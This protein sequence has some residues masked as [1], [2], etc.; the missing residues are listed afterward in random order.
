MD[1]S[2]DFA[3]KVHIAQESWSQ[4]ADAKAAVLFSIVGAFLA[5]VVAILTSSSLAPE[6]RGWRL[7]LLAIGLIGALCAGSLSGLVLAPRL[8]SA[9]ELA[10]EKHVI[11]FGHLR[12]WE[13]NALKGKLVSMSQDEQLTQLSA[14]LVRISQGNWLKFRLLLGALFAVSIAASLVVI[15]LVWPH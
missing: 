1:Q 2:L 9:K 6:V 13:P 10:A 4:R 12:A 14:Q 8:G 5:V 7:V 3:W 15:A 11:F